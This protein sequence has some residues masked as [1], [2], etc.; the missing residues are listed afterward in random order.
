M[1]VRDAESSLPA[2]IASLRS[3]TYE[4]WEL[5]IV[6]DGSVDRSPEIAA[7]AAA[8]DARIRLIRGDA[9]LGLPARLNQL[10]DAAGGTLFAR[11][12]ADDIAYPERLARQ[13]AHLERHPEVDLLG[14]SMVVFG[15]GG[16]AIGKRPAPVGH[17]EICAH[18]AGG[19]RLFHPTWVGR[20]E[21]FRRYRY[22][23]AARRWEDQ[24]LLYRAH[25][26]SCFANLSEP[27][28]GYREEHLVLRKLLVGR[29]N[30]ARRTARRLWGERRRPA[31]LA[32]V[33]TQLAKGSLDTVAVTTGLEHRLLRQRAGPLSPEERA[34]W[35]AVWSATAESE[36]SER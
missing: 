28:L 33:G 9:P 2:S 11:M 23:P 35:E 13:V 34:E 25:R 22:S 19:F 3:Q 20:L 1:S 27:L 16:R 21:W 31:A 32:A 6:D 4:D 26:D 10:L 30:L 5:L 7:S 18:P 29:A 8:D 14:A 15:R 17:G 36:S 12:D 24:D